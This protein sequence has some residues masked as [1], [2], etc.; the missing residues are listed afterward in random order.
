MSRPRGR[1]F[2]AVVCDLFTND[3]VGAQRMRDLSALASELLESEG[4]FVTNNHGQARS[5]ALQVILHSF[6]VGSS[7]L[8]SAWCFPVPLEDMAIIAVSKCGDMPSNWKKRL[9]R[10]QE[11][12]RAYALE[13]IDPARVFVG[14]RQVQ[15]H[16]R[17]EWRD[18]EVCEEEGVKV[19]F[20]PGTY[21]ASRGKR[22]RC[23][24]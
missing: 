24:A 13:H 9:E 23:D 21:L 5:E 3:D 11:P 4:V 2:Q 6:G 22:K 14:Y 15:R 1:K 17:T 20:L 16:P 18:A 12:L 10:V 19:L 7:S 8:L